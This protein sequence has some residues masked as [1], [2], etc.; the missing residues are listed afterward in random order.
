MSAPHPANSRAMAKNTTR[1]GK[2]NAISIAYQ[3]S[4]R[5]P[6]AG[7]R[8]AGSAPMRAPGP[9]RWSLAETNTNGLDT[10]R[11]SIADLQSRAP[12]DQGCIT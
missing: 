11:M 9:L 8:N 4:Q 10:I 6:R 12:H 7:A 3:K 1:A 2:V 5:A